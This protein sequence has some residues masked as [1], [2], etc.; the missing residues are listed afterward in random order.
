MFIRL[1]SRRG[2]DARCGGTY[3]SSTQLQDLAWETEEQVNSAELESYQPLEA[4]L[5]VLST[6]Y[7]YDNDDE[8]LTPC[9]QFFR[10]CS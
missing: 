1:C 10:E 7:R 5:R 3:F 2:R 8:L 9:E 4:M 6:L